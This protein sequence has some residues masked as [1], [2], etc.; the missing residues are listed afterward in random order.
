[1]TRIPRIAA[2]CALVVVLAASAFAQDR[3]TVG[4]VIDVDEGRNRLM[5][6]LDDA[7]A[8][9]LTIETDAISTTFHGFGTMIA[10]KPEIFTGSRGL[11][12][13]RLGDRIEARGSYRT[14][15]AVRATQVTLLGRSIPASPTG[16]GQ[17]RDP[18]T[19]ASTPTDDRT[20]TVLPSRIEGT[21]RQ[22]NE[23]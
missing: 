9:R 2:L 10:G 20:T 5:I 19:S 21:V 18:A 3:P 14:E 22:I 23:N 12:N 7:A 1:M 11:S 15:G 16:V 13:V 17:T 6:E 4:T 8:T